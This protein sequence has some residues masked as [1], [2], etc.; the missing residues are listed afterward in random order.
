MRNLPK[1]LS[2]SSSYDPRFSKNSP[3]L[4]FSDTNHSRRERKIK[5]QGLLSSLVR[6]FWPIWVFGF[7]FQQKSSHLKLK[8]KFNLAY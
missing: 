3:A 4:F 1:S 8:N 7:D 6:F 2:K 5:L